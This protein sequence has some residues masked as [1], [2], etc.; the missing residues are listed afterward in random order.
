MLA[1]ILAMVTTKFY[2]D[3]RA[4]KKGNPAPLKISVTKKGVTSHI[5][6]NLS[7]LP[8]QWDNKG[9]KIKYHP[10]KQNLNIYK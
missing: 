3:C 5:P 10:N 9:Q 7:L 1:S 8:N 2:L 6:L 4:V